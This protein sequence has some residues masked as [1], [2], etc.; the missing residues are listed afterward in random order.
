MIFQCIVIKSAIEEERKIQNELRIKF[1]DFCIDEKIM[2]FIEPPPEKLPAMEEVRTDRF[3]IS[4]LQTLVQE[5]QDLAKQYG[6]GRNCIPDKIIVDLFVRKLENSKTLG[7]EGSLPEDWR[8]MSEYHF[9]NMIRNLDKYNTGVVNWKNLATFII[10]LK[11]II[12]A[13]KNI[14]SYKQGLDFKGAKQL[15]IGQF[16]RVRLYLNNIEVRLKHGSMKLSSHK[17]EIIH[18]ISREF[19]ISRNFCLKSTKIPTLIR[20]V[21]KST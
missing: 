10:L 15:E 11:S 13:D 2:N 20:S 5:L 16:S 19:N 3:S 17:T 1:M 8:F 4:Q 14:E 6:N 21:L 7:D 12:P 18:I 9:Q